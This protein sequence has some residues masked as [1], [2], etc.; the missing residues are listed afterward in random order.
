MFMVFFI[1]YIVSKYCSPYENFFADLFYTCDGYCNSGSLFF[2][3]NPEEPEVLTDVLKLTFGS[4][5]N[6]CHTE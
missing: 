2:C 6:S 5:T 3:F 1:D 4:G